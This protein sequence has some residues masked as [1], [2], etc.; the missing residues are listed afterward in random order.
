MPVV[1]YV[2]AVA[3]AAA[4]GTILGYGIRSFVAKKKIAEAESNADKIIKDAQL[5]EK[6]LLLQAKNKSLQMIEESKREDENRRKELRLIQQ[7][8]EKHEIGYEQR[9]QDLQ[10]K[11]EQLF[12]KNNQV[13]ALRSELAKTKEEETKKLEAVAGL[14][15]EEAKDILMK[16]VEELVNE[17]FT[18]R[19]RK[20]ERVSSD[21]LEKKAR[22][23][24]GV[25][26]Q[27]IASSHA[28]ETTTT[29]VHLPNDEMKGR[30]IGK[31]G[32]NIKAIENLTGTEIIIDD[33]PETIT[34]SGFSPIRRQVAR[35]ALEKLMEDGRIH[36]TKIEEAVEA[37]KKDLAVDIK[38][39]GEDAL[40]ELG[41][42]LTGLD[43]KLIQILGRLKYRTS[44]GQNVLKHSIE[45]ASIAAVLASELGADVAICKKGGILHDIGKAVDHDVQG[46]HPEI[47]Y[48]IMKKFGLPEEI[49]YQSIG[50]HEDHPK[51]L[52][53]IIVKAADAIS[54]AR[55]GARKDTYEFYVQRLEE[56]EKVASSFPGIEKAYA[57]QAGREVRV[58]VEP[59]AVDDFGAFR[60]AKDIA[61][62]IES[63]LK[64]P[65]EIKVNVIR[66]TRVVEYAR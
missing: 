29:S 66:E 42:P 33:T 57:I 4:L 31:E 5:K 2:V 19:L 11:Q 13:E 39:A 8:L 30:I 12:E 43:P 55:P 56:L 36:P 49:C 45:V 24:L 47:G 62:K 35:I 41:V 22:N 10:K 61:C 51:T 37:A 44:Y 64:Y 38:K 40:Y 32:R 27:R 20:L 48:N 16:N 23:M 63:E 52:E 53:A 1:F 34:V 9:V 17:E 7:K 65:G 54:G 6:D 3:G 14:S 60:M 26:I 46:A 59:K 25:V 28:V 58:F 18:S 15:K 50:H 21:E